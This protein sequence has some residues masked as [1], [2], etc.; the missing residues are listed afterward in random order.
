[1]KLLNMNSRLKELLAMILIGDGALN[2]IQPR[3]HT[4]TWSCGPKLYKNAARKLET[5]PG[6]TRGLDL[7]LMAMGFLLGRNAAKT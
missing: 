6:I 2:L 7:A 3:R 1:M 4:A 5:H